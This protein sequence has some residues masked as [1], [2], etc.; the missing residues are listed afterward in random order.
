[1]RYNH[2]ETEFINFYQLLTHQ[3]RLVRVLSLSLDMRHSQVDARPCKHLQR[4]SLSQYKSTNISLINSW[5][6]ITDFH[7][8][9]EQKLHAK[10]KNLC[11]LVH[12]ETMDP[13]HQTCCDLRKPLA[14][15]CQKMCPLEPRT[16]ADHGP[17]C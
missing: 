14:L 3:L 13:S 6:E 7:T 16:L 4:S 9:L 5:S 15:L 17:G 2:E 12:N 10:H 1:M 8:L 11:R